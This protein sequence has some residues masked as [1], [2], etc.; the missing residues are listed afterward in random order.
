MPS[1]SPPWANTAVTSSQPWIPKKSRVL[2]VTLTRLLLGHMTLTAHLHRLPG[3]ARQAV[4]VTG[5][6]LRAHRNSCP[7]SRACLAQ[8][9]ASSWAA[10]QCT[11]TMRSKKDQRITEV[12]VSGMEAYIPHTFSN[13][14]ARQPWFN[15]ACSHAVRDREV[16]H[17]RYHLHLTKDVS[18][19]ALRTIKG[20]DELS[21]FV[22]EVQ[23]SDLDRVVEMAKAIL[24]Q[25]E[26][27]MEM[28]FSSEVH[29][30]SAVCKNC[31]ISEECGGS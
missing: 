7:H 1:A 30:T 26:G 19:K 18:P 14:K 24:P 13:P 5:K 9:E 21:L 4:P 28:R 29:S 16:A 3:K 25:H 11:T 10:R 23:D 15:S 17:K 2:D 20:V 6:S 31:W 22:S 12:I 8:S 27:L